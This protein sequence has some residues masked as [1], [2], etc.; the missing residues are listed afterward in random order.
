MHDDLREC[1]AS[2]QICWHFFHILF[3]DDFC[4]ILDERL[5]ICCSLI[6]SSI[7]E[8]NIITSLPIHNWFS[9]YFFEFLELYF[10]RNALDFDPFSGETGDLLFFMLSIATTKSLVFQRTWIWLA[11]LAARSEFQ[12]PSSFTFF[13]ILFFRSFFSFFLA[14]Q[15]SRSAIVP[16]TFPGSAASTQSEIEVCG[17]F[18][19]QHENVF[20]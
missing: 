13:S 15:M 5:G 4:P 3:F 20:E 1:T 2:K 19:F 16:A 9:I 11:I 12:S 18:P 6:Q 7:F 10:F 17:T 14:E 8:H